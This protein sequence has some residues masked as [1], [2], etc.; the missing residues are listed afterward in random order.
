M[1]QLRL[2][3]AQGTLFEDNITPCGGKWKA[4][5]SWS[6]SLDAQVI[7]HYAKHQHSHPGSFCYILPLYEIIGSAWA[8]NPKWL[9]GVVI[10]HPIVPV[11]CERLFPIMP[12][13]YHGYAT[14][15]GLLYHGIRVNVLYIFIYIQYHYYH[16]YHY[17]F[18]Y[19]YYYYY[20]FFYDYY[21]YHFHSYYFYYYILLSLLLLLLLFL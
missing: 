7:D 2:S 3:P 5:W 15:N 10:A 6:L 8:R 1:R 4:M 17:Y 20:Y 21:Y 19:Y 16:Y 14:T 11:T 12:G 13:F 18:Y 9:A